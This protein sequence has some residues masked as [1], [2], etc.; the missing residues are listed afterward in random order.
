MTTQVAERHEITGLIDEV[1]RYLI[2]V[3]A[4][5]AEG[6]APQWL[7]EERSPAP[8]AAN[9]VHRFRP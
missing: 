9:S 8:A 2:V 3:E 5:R 7:P 4:F 1:R 6:R